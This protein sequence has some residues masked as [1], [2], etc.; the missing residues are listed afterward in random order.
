MI[1]KC[2]KCQGLIDE[3]PII[4]IGSC[5]LC[6]DLICVGHEFYKFDGDLYCEDCID[7]MRPA[8]VFCMLGGEKGDV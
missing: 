8:E 1:C 6:E 7:D 5:V 2:S 3:E 4:T